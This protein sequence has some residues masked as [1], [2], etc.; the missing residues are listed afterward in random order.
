MAKVST[1]RRCLSLGGV[2]VLILTGSVLSQSGVQLGKRALVVGINHY[3]QET[4]G[5]AESRDLVTVDLGNGVKMELVRIPAG[6]FLMGSPKDDKDRSDD[7]TQHSVKI[8]NDFYLAAYPLTVGQFRRFVERA[9]Y[10]TEAETDGE[11]G[12][13][14][15]KEEQEFEGRNPNY[16]WRHVGWQQSDQHP[17]VNVTWNDARRFCDWLSRQEGKTYR[18][19]T[20]AEWE[21]ACRAG[22][23]TRYYHGDD[24]RNLKVLA[25]IVK[26]RLDK[27]KS[28]DAFSPV[29]DDGRLFTAPGG[30]LPPNAWGLYD[31][32]GN[33]WQ[34]CADWYGPYPE[35]DVED[36]HGPDKGTNRV[37]RGASCCYH[38]RVCRSAQRDRSLPD[39]RD[40]LYGIR[41]CLSSFS[42]TR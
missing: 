16:S 4:L 26:S 34:W 2:T 19:P 15:N 18:L 25:P 3:A 31:M 10:K 21:Y 29:G 11:G 41:V 1:N 7:E 17:V 38:P 40:F 20:E 28:K 32:Q 23:T 13:G 27:E 14:F 9:H 35:Q 30:A 6:K 36:P 12:W 5:P 24:A 22:T 33:V 39:N 42:K 8:S 37:L